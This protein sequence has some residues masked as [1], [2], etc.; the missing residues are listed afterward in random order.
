MKRSVLTVVFFLCAPFLMHAQSVW[1]G[2]CAVGAYGSFPS[3]GLYGASNSFP[4]NTLVTVENPQ[5]NKKATVLIIDRLNDSGLFMLL[6]RDAGS[7]I[8]LSTGEVSQVKVTL[9]KR[10]SPVSQGPSDLPYS[11][12][13]DVFP[14][15]SVGN[16]N[17]LSFLDQYLGSSGA[18][19]PRP[20][21]TAPAPPEAP[22]KEQTT[23]QPA[24]APSSTT[25]PPEAGPAV[26]TLAP[27]PEQKPTP[28]QPSTAPP[29]PELAQ[30]STQPQTSGAEPTPPKPPQPGVASTEQGAQPA[31]GVP[32]PG[33]GTQEVPSATGVETGVQPAPTGA[34]QATG[35]PSAAPQAGPPTVTGPTVT[36]LRPVQTPREAAPALAELATPTVPERAGGTPVVSELQSSPTTRASRR[37]PEVALGASPAVPEIRH[38]GPSVS[39]LAA[40]TPPASSLPSLGLALA[41]PSAPAAVSAVPQVTELAQARPRISPF[42]PSVSVVPAIPV[43]S[44]G[45]AKAPPSGP[46]VSALAGARPPAAAPK[47]AESELPLP[48]MVTPEISPLAS[49]QPPATSGP[50]VSGA[51]ASPEIAAKPAAQAG[52]VS[53]AQ[54]PAVAQGEAGA[55]PAPSKPSAA[56]PTPSGAEAAGAAAHMVGRIPVRPATALAPASY[57]VQLGVY[58]E[59]SAA[60]ALAD[61]LSPD[62]PVSVYAFSQN[63][64]PLYK[65]MIGPLNSDESGTL[66]YLFMAQ[67]YKDAF[68]RKGE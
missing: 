48:F 60:V 35:P 15:A 53:G 37:E 49:T 23:I 58:G 33:S 5:T 61:N 6:S 44:Q 17:S 47:V 21:A 9:T 56:Q 32:P 14:A 40:T 10:S 2:S 24:Q 52:G 38:P 4:Q 64:K 3:T 36:E 25:K 12:D 54:P 26:S 41:S 67:G 27:Q 65:V 22:P 20:P 7:A 39:G 13:P 11:P 18:A 59:S 30:L 28:V 8:G 46:L 51:V 31:Q 34:E 62:Y 50:V 45:V 57:Y 43:E 42:A 19:Q 63:K 1:E 29:A 55:P 16:P 68:V 66:L